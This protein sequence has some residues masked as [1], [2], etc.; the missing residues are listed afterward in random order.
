MGITQTVKRPR[1]RY[2][3]THADLARTIND[4]YGDVFP[5]E[6]LVELINITDPLEAIDF[7]VELKIYKR[8]EF[9]QLRSIFVDV[10]PTNENFFRFFKK[11][12]A[13]KKVYQL[14]YIPHSQ[15]IIYGQN[16][17]ELI[18]YARRE[19]NTN[20]NF[21]VTETNFSFNYL[22]L[23]VCLDQDE[24]QDD[25]FFSW[26]KTLNLQ[27]FHVNGPPIK[28][29]KYLNFN[30]RMISL[31]E[32]HTEYYLANSRNLLRKLVIGNETDIAPSVDRMFGRINITHFEN[33]EII[34]VYC[35]PVI[36]NLK[37]RFKNKPNKTLIKELVLRY[38]DTGQ[39][40][41][42]DLIDK[43]KDFD[44][45]LK[46]L[47]EN[48]WSNQNKI[49]DINIQIKGVLFELDQKIRYYVR[50][51]RR[52]GKIR[53][54]ESVYGT[55]HQR[56]I[57]YLYETYPPKDLIIWD[58]NNHTNKTYET[59][60]NPLEF[61][62]GWN[63]PANFNYGAVTNFLEVYGLSAYK[64][65][66]IKKVIYKSPILTDVSNNFTIIQNKNEYFEMENPG[67]QTDLRLGL[68]RINNIKGDTYR[69][70]YGNMNTHRPVVYK[71]D[72]RSM[73]SKN[74]RLLIL[75]NEVCLRGVKTKRN[76]LIEEKN[77]IDHNKVFR[78]TDEHH[79]SFILL[80][81][82]N[83]FRYIN[84][85]CQKIGMVADK[86]KNYPI[87]YSYYKTTVK[88]TGAPGTSINYIHTRNAHR[89][90]Q[91]S[92]AIQ[93]F[94]IDNLMNIEVSYINVNKIMYKFEETKRLLSIYSK[95]FKNQTFDVNL[96]MF[97]TPKMERINFDGTV[98]RGGESDFIGG[99]PNNRIADL[100]QS[101][102]MSQCENIPNIYKV[103]GI[104]NDKKTIDL[105]NT[106]ILT[107]YGDILKNP[108]VIINDKTGGLKFAEIN[109]FK[110]VLVNYSML[111]PQNLSFASAFNGDIEHVFNV[112]NGAIVDYGNNGAL[113]TMFMNKLYGRFDNLK[114]VLLK[115]AGRLS[116]INDIIN[117]SNQTNTPL[118]ANPCAGLL[119][120][121]ENLFIY[122]Y[123]GFREL[124]SEVIINSNF[125]TDI[126]FEILPFYKY[127]PHS[128]DRTQD[129]KI[130]AFLYYSLYGAYYARK[131]KVLKQIIL[132]NIL[133][134]KL[135]RETTKPPTP[136]HVIKLNDYD[137]GDNPIFYILS[138]NEQHVDFNITMIDESMPPKKKIINKDIFFKIANSSKTHI[139]VDNP[140]T[141]KVKLT[142]YLQKTFTNRS[143]KTPTTHINNFGTFV[144]QISD[145]PRPI[146]SKGNQLIHTYKLVLSKEANTV[147]IQPL[148]RIFRVI[149]V[150]SLDSQPL[151]EVLIDK[152]LKPYSVSHM[153]YVE[154]ILSF[155]TSNRALVRS[156]ISNV[157]GLNVLTVYMNNFLK[158]SE[159]DDINSLRLLKKMDNMNTF[160]I[161]LRNV[162][163]TNIEFEKGMSLYPDNINYYVDTTSISYSG[164]TFKSMLNVQDVMEV[165]FE[166]VLL[167]KN[168]FK[169]Y[170]NYS[171]QSSSFTLKEKNSKEELNVN[172]KLSIRLL[173]KFRIN[174]QTLQ[175]VIKQ[176][177]KVLEI[178][179]K[180]L[181]LPQNLKLLNLFIKCATL[182][183]LNLIGVPPNARIIIRSKSPTDS[184]RVNVVDSDYI[185]MYTN[186][187]VAVFGHGPK[188]TVIYIE[189]SKIDKKYTIIG[190][191]QNTIKSPDG[192][193]LLTRDVNNCILKG[194]QSYT[195]PQWLFKYPIITRP[196]EYYHIHE[197]LMKYLITP[198]DKDEAY[199]K[200]DEYSDD[201][202]EDE[203]EGEEEE[204]DIWDI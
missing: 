196:I 78:R 109:G 125:F 74:P 28:P 110:R 172:E 122:V 32:T 158:F 25:V 89:Y 94:G 199:N 175:I 61:T 115:L 16:K 187:P 179:L 38:W 41:V 152:P 6:V 46:R 54:Y 70:I 53:I 124:Q 85:D 15:D 24:I 116:L 33:L 180:D 76:L 64:D 72:D 19:F 161:K 143:I 55:Y 69:F 167:N 135:G 36:L 160:N 52:N 50:G 30:W 81:G 201:E 47:N 17:D 84:R 127:T 131:M 156:L 114:R 88:I 62:Q 183:Q 111:Y 176:D 101:I 133:R 10:D 82:N 100:R 4:S 14:S 203:E 8:S 193:E 63:L 5:H 44:K 142:G 9:S 153:I 93:I 58:F 22:D 159:K 190:R 2:Y 151:K 51:I 3:D 195:P 27:G 42:K 59:I 119:K 162:K 29:N 60:T 181:V 186:K 198:G 126:F 178:S 200:Y 177:L 26:I 168:T 107:I 48:Q 166:N 188:Q 73:K 56:L 154:D 148:T 120:Q 39:D 171:Y 91:L 150:K 106:K 37:E 7:D 121:I 11:V 104:A 163:N 97:Y 108:A 137:V 165:M 96:N 138:R 170:F 139:R 40:V 34:N 136:P 185:L 169:R 92:N 157:M 191:V 80:L 189:G 204:E 117:I 105:E 184:I 20:L 174:D 68:V 155:Y 194:Q 141:R 12:K 49:N 128:S 23:C 123:N 43:L 144:V 1:T 145:N 103:S 146:Q 45:E 71:I 118:S 149:H 192:F 35:V 66:E 67:V 134:F 77:L 182:V 164:D 113:H 140:P 83:E 202:E 90:I 13:S 18:K 102:I 147:R 173:S 98:G 132:H 99:I 86:W 75:L 65:F 197:G 130:P 112:M 57:K 21:H 129:Q 95:N 31:F 87:I 79:N